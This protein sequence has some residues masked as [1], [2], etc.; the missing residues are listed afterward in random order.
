MI[1]IQKRLFLETIKFD[2]SGWGYKKF[3]HVDLFWEKS[4]EWY[5]GSLKY[6]GVAI[7]KNKKETG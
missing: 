3:R 5:N 7:K 2:Q 6:K 1:P 4:R